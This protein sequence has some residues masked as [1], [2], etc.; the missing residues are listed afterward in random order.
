MSMRLSPMRRRAVELA[1]GYARWWRARYGEEL[2]DLVETTGI[3][4][5]H[6]AGLAFNGWSERLRG[7]AASITR[8]WV[9]PRAS[10]A[11]LDSRLWHRRLRWP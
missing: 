6:V 7:P 10:D 1:C 9:W 2:A 3:S 4:W 5:W 8:C 11:R